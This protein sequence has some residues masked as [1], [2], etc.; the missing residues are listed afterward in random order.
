[1]QSHFKI[2]QLNTRIRELLATNQLYQEK[3]TALLPGYQKIP[4]VGH[5]R[6]GT[7]ESQG[8][9]SPISKAVWQLKQVCKYLR[10]RPI[11]LWDS[12]Y[13]CAPFI[14][15]T[16]DIKADKL[17]RLRSNLCLWAAPPKYSGRGRPRL[18]GDKFKLNDPQTWTEPT[19]TL[20]INDPKLG[21]LRIRVWDNLHFRGAALHPMDI[22]LVERLNENGSLRVV[23]P[24][25]LAWVGDVMPTLDEVWRLYLRRFAV[26]QRQSISQAT[27][28]LDCS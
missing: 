9:E 19:Q 10:A 16:A 21:K 17:V 11:S 5:Y 6:F 13:G 18:H 12:E 23:K 24:M 2:E 22:V 8:A 28:A 14:L 1:M 15:K 25:W 7:S 20:N 26:D 3:V 4:G 27:F